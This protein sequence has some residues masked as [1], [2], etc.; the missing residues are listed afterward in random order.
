MNKELELKEK[1]TQER[2]FVEI[3]QETKDDVFPHS[4][5]TLP[6][7]VA[8]MTNKFLVGIPYYRQS[9]YFLIMG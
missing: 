2:D 9:K 4:I 8:V 5:Y 3:Y 1:P 6:L 7:A